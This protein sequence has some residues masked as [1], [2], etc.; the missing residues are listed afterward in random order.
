LSK[1]RVIGCPECGGDMRYIPSTKAYVCQSC[2]LT[3]TYE[4]LMEERRKLREELGLKFEE[5]SER[6]KIRKEYLKWWLSKKKT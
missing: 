3:L 5:E 4:E 1:R 6:E 2:G